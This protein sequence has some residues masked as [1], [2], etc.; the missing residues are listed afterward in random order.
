M[1]KIVL[2]LL[3]IPYIAFTEIH[4]EFQIGKELSDNNIAFTEIELSYDF[5][6]WQI[7]FM[8]YGSITTWFYIDWERLVGQ[9]PFRTVYDIGLRTSYKIFFIDINHFCN[10]P[11][12]ASYSISKWSDMKWQDGLTTLSIG[13]KW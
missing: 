9:S 11:I 12:Y 5:D 10:H 7:N 2:L 6:I 3:L 4:G 1:F 13:V 8:P